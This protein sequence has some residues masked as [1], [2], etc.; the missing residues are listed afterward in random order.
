MP[1]SAPYTLFKG[2]A[3]TQSRRKWAFAPWTWPLSL[4]R[5]LRAWGSRGC[6]RRPDCRLCCR[7]G[8]PYC[9]ADYH[10]KF[11][12]RCDGCEKYITGHVL[13]VRGPAWRLQA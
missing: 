4:A 9:E 6:P 1:V 8:L 12:I 3:V 5:T 10:S 13:E 7:D 2:C 11:G